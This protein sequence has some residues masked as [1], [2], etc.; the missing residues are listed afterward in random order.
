MLNLSESMWNLA[1]LPLKTSYLHYHNCYDHKTW[2]DGGSPWGAPT[3]KV[4]KNLGHVVLQDHV[5]N[6]YLYMSTTAV[7]MA[8]KLEMMVTYLE[9]VLPI[10]W[11]NPL[12]PWSC[13]ITWK[14]K[15]IYLHYRGDYGHQTWQ[16][17]D[18]PWRA[19]IHKLAVTFGS[20]DRLTILYLHYHNAH[21][22]Q[23]WQGGD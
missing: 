2:Q 22:Y 19:S 7:P 13:K 20:R 5:T 6:Y 17:G 9:E 21:S 18:L 3:N 10:M 11:R 12:I 8:T 4:T 15:T 14:T 1:L 16:D 23:T